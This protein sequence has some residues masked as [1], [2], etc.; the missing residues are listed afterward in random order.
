MPRWR[1]RFDAT[2]SRHARALSTRA[3]PLGAC[4]KAPARSRSPSL[5]R[6]PRV[7]TART[8]RASASRGCPAARSSTMRQ[9]RLRFTLGPRPRRAMADKHPPGASPPDGVCSAHRA[10]GERWSATTAAEGR[11]RPAT[12]RGHRVARRQGHPRGLRVVS[13]TAE[14]PSSRPSTR[15]SATAPPRRR[16]RHRRQGHRARRRA[17][18]LPVGASGVAAAVARAVEDA[19]GGSSGRVMLLAP[20]ARA[21]MY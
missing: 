5:R 20:E 7:S 8:L 13:A 2:T 1:R 16:R 18:R 3:P 10:P 19:M 21:S 15:R 6:I 4:I 14:P 17:P 9:G 12:P 11:R